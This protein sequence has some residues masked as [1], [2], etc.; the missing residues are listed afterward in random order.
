M[1]YPVRLEAPKAMR[2][3]LIPLEGGAPIDVLKDVTLVGRKEDCDLRL[4]HK[5]VSK[6]HCVIVKTDGLLLL[7]D[8]GSTNGT[9]VNGT[10]IRRA[11]LLPNDQLTIANYSFKIRLG[12]EEPPPSPEEH[13]QQL[14]AKEM[15]NLLRPAAAAVGA[16]PPPLVDSS[17]EMP[18]VPVQNVLPDVYPEEKKPQ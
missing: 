7:R 3:Q 17:V 13:T 4:D 16:G 5:S 11:A 15:A 6:L 14:D 8:L 2:A 10:R 18:I 1:K 9:R 12:G